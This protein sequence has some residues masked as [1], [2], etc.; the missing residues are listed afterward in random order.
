MKRIF[1]AVKVEPGL[2]LLKAFNDLKIKLS[3][4]SIKWTD[5]GNTHL[6]ISFLGD[7]GEKRISLL[8]EMLAEKCS[9]IRRFEFTMEGMGVFR[10]FRDPKVIWVGVKKSGSLNQLNKIITEGLIE[11]G[12]SVEE[13]DFSPHLTLGRIRFVKNADA[14]KRALERY[15]DTEFQN[16]KVDEVIL[17]ESIL[18]QTGAVYKTLMK[19]SLR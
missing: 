1:I 9:D 17:F 16:I 5:I 8:T 18:M 10:N 14:V 12:F 3:G 4:E 7:T 13:R 19:F 11:K 2:E 6:T 15:R